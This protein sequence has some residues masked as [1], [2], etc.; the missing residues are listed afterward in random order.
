MG[1]MVDTAFNGAGA[2][3]SERPGSVV[4]GGPAAKVGL[5]SGD[6]ILKIDGV[7]INS[8]DELIVAIRSHVV[9]DVISVTYTRNGKVSTVK[10]TLVA[11]KN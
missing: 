7:A 9:G 5:M 11:A 4:V 8:S 6:V 2:K 10:I 1:I 3:I